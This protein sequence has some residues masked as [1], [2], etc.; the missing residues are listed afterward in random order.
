MFLKFASISHITF[1]QNLKY[2]KQK[3][4]SGLMDDQMVRTKQQSIG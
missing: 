3:D 4:L 2:Q 1:P